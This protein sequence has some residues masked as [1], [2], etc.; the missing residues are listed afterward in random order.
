MVNGLPVVLSMGVFDSGMGETEVALLSWKA[1]TQIQAL[2]SVFPFLPI[3]KLW[4]QGAPSDH[5]ACGRLWTLDGQS[6][7]PL[8]E[9]DRRLITWLITSTAFSPSGSLLAST[10]DGVK[11]GE[12]RLW[13][14]NDVRRS[15]IFTTGLVRVWSLAFSPDGATLA[16]GG[17]SILLY[18]LEGT[19]IAGLHPESLTRMA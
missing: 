1:I 8:R 19:V 2:S 18:D 3:G 14:I 4:H 6:H 10:E 11:V 7:T 5:S 17:R 12:I 9:D 13:E 15:R 16:A